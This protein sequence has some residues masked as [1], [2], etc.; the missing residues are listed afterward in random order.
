LDL[1]SGVGLFSIYLSDRIQFGVAIESNL[2]A[3]QNAQINASENYV[4][5][6]EFQHGL[7]ENTVFNEF[8]VAILDPPRSGCSAQVLQQL[9][10]KIRNQIIYISCDPTTLA[11][12]LKELCRL[13][14]EI[15]LVQP[16]D[17]FPQTYHIETLV[18]LRKTIV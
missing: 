16:F 17:M 15:N 4:S 12:D 7:V 18:S 10:E 13:G 6:I 11:R 14:W 1:Y 5:Q 3:V 2:S 8:E 9:N